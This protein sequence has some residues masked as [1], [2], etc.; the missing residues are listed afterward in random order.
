MQ[1]AVKTDGT[2]WCWGVNDKGQLGQ[3]D[4]TNRSSPIQVPGTT[5]SIV[6]TAGSAVLA[7]KTDNTLWAWGPNWD[8]QLGQNQAPGIAY[9]FSS[10]VQIPGVWDELDQHNFQIGG[11]TIK[12]IGEKLV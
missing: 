7:K 6:K 4:T 12:A 5:W 11:S 9:G 1:A 2:L 10:P 8:G 3:N